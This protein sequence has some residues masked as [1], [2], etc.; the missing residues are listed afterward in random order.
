M[1]RIVSI[2]L[3][4]VLAFVSCGP[5]KAVEPL[6]QDYAPYIKAFTGGI[7]TEDATIRI[8]LAEDATGQPTDGLFSFKPALKGSVKWN[9]PQSVAFVPEEGALKVGQ[10]YKASFALGKLIPGAPEEFPFG[11][12][13]KGNLV[14]VQ[15]TG[16]EPDN[17][18]AFRV[19]QASV[20][21]NFVEIRMS[22]APANASVKG[23]VELSGGK[24]GILSIGP[25]RESTLCVAL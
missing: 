16:A 13:V 23:L 20:K 18:K 8:E 7:V 19:V 10:T 9:S 22:E 3:A 6:A 5:K 12:T 11:I 15:E 1:R 24:L 21:E 17:G 4:G 14:S 2:V 25:A